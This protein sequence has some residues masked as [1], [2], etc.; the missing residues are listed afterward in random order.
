[1]TM[2]KKQALALS[3]DP[4]ARAMVRRPEGLV[5]LF[6]ARLS[7]E[8]MAGSALYPASHIKGLYKTAGCEL[9]ETIRASR[10]HTLTLPN[11]DVFNIFLAASAK[12]D[13]HL[14][15]G[16]LAKS[17]QHP[18]VIVHVVDDPALEER[19]AVIRRHTDQY[20]DV[21]DAAGEKGA[22]RLT[23]L[24]ARNYAAFHVIEDF[25]REHDLGAELD[26]DY[27][28]VTDDKYLFIRCSAEFAEELWK[29]K[30]PGFGGYGYA[31]TPQSRPG[32]LPTVK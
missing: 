14:R 15:D 8:D 2:D 6:A 20:A 28:I 12:I 27:H 30:P 9:P 11:R 26:P 21:L 7:Q 1:M 23:R 4:L 19:I 18:H 17:R 25:A 13:P 32:Y 3:R 5:A 24:Q 29:F 22:H 31:P 10:Q 16:Y